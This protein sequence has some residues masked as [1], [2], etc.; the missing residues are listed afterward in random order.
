M[1][2]RLSVSGRNP[3]GLI[4]NWFKT[5]ILSVH[6]KLV[7]ICLITWICIVAIV[8]GLL[9]LHRINS[10]RPF[11]N[12]VVQYFTYILADLGTPPSIEEAQ[13]IYTRT[14]LKILFK[15]KEEHWSLIEDFPEN[16]NIRYRSFSDSDTIGVGRFHG[17]HFLRFNHE[18]GIFI[19][20]FSGFDQANDRDLPMILILIGFLTLIL[21]G[22]YLAIKKTLKP[23]TWLHQ[24]VMEVGRGNLVHTLPQ[25]RKDEFG[26]LA[27]AFNTMTRQLRQM[28]DLKQQLL[29]D[30]SH[31]LRSPLTRMKLA[32]EFVNDVQIKKSLGE[33]IREVEAMVTAILENARL[34]HGHSTL[35]K[36]GTDLTAIVKDIVAGFENRAP[37]ICLADH[38]PIVFDFDPAR[39]K[40]VIINIIE[41]ALKYSS[42][43]DPAVEVHFTTEPCW[44]R[45]TIEDRGIGMDQS[46]LPLIMEPFYR[47]DQSRSKKTGG[48]GLGL[49]LC[50]TIMDAHGG[51]LEINSAPGKGTCV[52]L[53]LPIN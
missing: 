29:R 18:T 28:M 1:G 32:L 40:I 24:G 2:I 34:H 46:K 25:D 48:F 49:S 3:G 17:R 8:G 14:G 33:D 26:K 30:V 53:I 31:E 44:T 43:D 9:I 11:Q 42:Q 35:N 45:V 38:A 23:I 52:T 7:V 36:K 39:I 27:R 5:I 51:T 50:K 20:E 13:K 12:N 16:K 37:G 22:T 6:A 4:M 19:F 41:N 10:A 21:M 15:G 47:L